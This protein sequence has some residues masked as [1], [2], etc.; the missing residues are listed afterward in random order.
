MLRIAWPYDGQVLNRWQGHP[1]PEGLQV[2]VQGQVY[3]RATVA[4][5]GQPAAA[6][7]GQFAA[8]ITLQPGANEV[9]ARADGAYGVAEHHIQVWYD[10][11]G[12]RRYRLSVDDNSFWL[13]E[14]GRNQLT[15]E[16]LFDCWYLR[17]WRDLHE[18]YGLRVVLNIYYETDDG[19]NLAQFPERYR[20]EFEAAAD[21]LKLAWHARANLPDRPYEY[22]G[23][24]RVAADY[25]LVAAEI[26]RFAGEQTLS[27]PTVVHWAETTAAGF[28]ALVDRGVRNMSGIFKVL[29]GRQV[30]NYYLRDERADLAE[31]CAQWI[32]RSNQVAFSQADITLNNTPL[33]QIAPHLEAL[34]HRPEHAEIMDLFTHEQYFWDFYPRYLPDH[35]QRVEEAVRWVTEHGYEPCWFHEGYLGGPEIRGL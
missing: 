8:T 31:Q 15:Y 21:F 5:N 26:L 16:S 25:D 1:G 17:L 13:R 19:F 14:I 32:D 2:H 12:L 35:P 7:T 23:Y 33:E 18:R 29:N 22:Q 30:G 28:Q 20:A 9:V 27:L 4:V 10:P 11:H 3:G 34:T 24:E 6:A